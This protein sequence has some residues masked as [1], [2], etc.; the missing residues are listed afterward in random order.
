MRRLSGEAASAR[1]A[2]AIFS[3]SSG[4]AARPPSFSRRSSGTPAPG[5]GRP[6]PQGVLFQPLADDNEQDVPLA[7]HQGGRFEHPPE[8]PV[9]AD[10]DRPGIHDDALVMKPV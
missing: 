4:G 5:R 9:T 6:R 1:T 8:G 2:A 3:G 7:G 10:A